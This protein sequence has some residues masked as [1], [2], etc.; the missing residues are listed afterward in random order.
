MQQLVNFN[1]I[2]EL[3]K[4]YEQLKT[5]I[6]NLNT[7]NPTMQQIARIKALTLNLDCKI[8]QLKTMLITTAL[9]YTGNL[10]KK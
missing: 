1:E 2:N 8:Q 5:E 7:I 9:M 10:Q 6:N 3:I 4:I